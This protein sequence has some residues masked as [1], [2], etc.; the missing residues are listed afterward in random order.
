MLAVADGMGGTLGGGEAATAALAALVEP[1]DGSAPAATRPRSGRHPAAP[2][3]QAAVRLESRT[4]EAVTRRSPGR[5][6][7]APG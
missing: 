5:S 4:V 6:R 7:P 2:G 3:G 1:L